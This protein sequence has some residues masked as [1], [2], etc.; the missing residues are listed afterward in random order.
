MLHPTLHAFGTDG[1][2]IRFGED[3]TQDANAAAITCAEQLQEHCGTWAIEI[4]SALISVLVRF[5]PSEISPQEAERALS[6]F[7]DAIDTKSL[8]T[9]QGRRFSIPCCFDP[10]YAPDMQDF[11]TALNMS[12]SQVI[13]TLTSCSV[14]VLTLGFAP[15]QPYLGLLPEAFFTPRRSALT[16]QVPK[17]ALVSAV[18]QL[19]IYAA[20]NPTGWYHIGQTPV[21]C[22]EPKAT[23][24]NMF[25]AG[26]VLTFHACSASEL[27]QYEAQLSP[28]EVV[29]GA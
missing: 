9:T 29:H 13:D 2:L 12:R 5:N 15:G 22:F 18:Q 4:T 6:Q 16:P 26:D 10:E 1:F 21:T 17:G 24:P 25:R 8:E 27:K 19:I 23:P 28:F 7:I 14:S 11:C 3:L 20:N